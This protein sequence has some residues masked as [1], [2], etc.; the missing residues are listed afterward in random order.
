MKIY[1]LLNYFLKKLYLKLW[2]T[3]KSYKGNIHLGSKESSLVKLPFTNKSAY[4]RP[5]SSDMG[6]VS[7]YI[8]DIYFSYSYL[9]TK[10]TNMNPTI[11]IDIGANIGMSSLG[12]LEEFTH[13]KK[14]IAIE[15]EDENFNILSKNFKYWKKEFKDIEFLPIHAIASSDK[16][17]NFHK[18]KSIN[19]LTGSNSASGTFRFSPDSNLNLD[20]KEFSQVVSIQD[21]FKEIPSEEVVIVKIDIEGGEEFLM[22]KNYDW[23]GSTAFITMEIHDRFHEDMLNSS[24]TSIEALCNFNFAIVPE[25][26]VLHCYNRNI[27]FPEK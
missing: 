20:N 18:Q 14:I 11:L 8:S 25:K 12:L 3:F 10:L 16:N 21:I 1:R 7:E 5:T 6:R 24:R 27:M 19:E 9:H 4:L 26:D 22:S 2:K 15:A 17:L 13:L 23:V